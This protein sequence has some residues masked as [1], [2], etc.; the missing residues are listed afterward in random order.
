[1]AIEDVRLLVVRPTDLVLAA[2][3]FVNFGVGSGTLTATSGALVEV[4]LPPQSTGE[5]AWAAGVLSVARVGGP[6][7]LTFSVAAGVV[8]PLTADGVLSALA[9]AV[10]VHGDAPAGA[11]PLSVELPWHIRFAPRPATTGDA[12]LSDVPGTAHAGPTGATGLWH[13]RLEAASGL[14]LVP[15]DTDLDVDVVPP[16]DQGR[17]DIVFGLGSPPG[18][19]PSAPFMD[20]SALGGTM[21]ATGTWQHFSWEHHVVLGRDMAV[22]TESRG[23]LYPFGHRAI[24]VKTSNRRLLPPGSGPADAG[25]LE[26]SWLIVPDPV[27]G[28]SADEAL[29]RVLPFSEVEILE[30]VVALGVPGERTVV[31]RKRFP[32]RLDALREEKAALEQELASAEAS[33][34]PLVE[35]AKQFIIDDGEAAKANLFAQVAPIAAE[36][37]ELEAFKTASDEWDQNHP[38]HFETGQRVVTD[39]VTGE[40]TIEEFSELV[41]GEPNPAPWSQALQNHLEA[42]RADAK[43]F[44]DAVAQ[45]DVNTQNQLAALVNEDAFLAFGGDLGAAMARVKQLRLDIPARAAFIT[46][47]EV[48]AQQDHPV[49]LWPLAPGGTTVQVPIRCDAVRMSMP[50]LFLHDE[51]IGDSEDWP[52]FAP[53][54]EDAARTEIANAWGAEQGRHVP[55]PGIPVDLV[56]APAPAP[57][58]ELPVRRLTFGGAHDGGGFRAILEEAEVVLAAAQELVPGVK[59]AV[60]VTYREAYRLSGEAEHAV[61]ELRDAIPVDFSNV[62]DRAGGLVAPNFAADVISRLHGPVPAGALVGLLPQQPDLATVFGTTKLLGMPLGA[63][64][65]PLTEAVPKPLTIVREPGGGARMSWA[66]LTLKDHGPLRVTKGKTK[67][68]LTVVRSP[69][70]TTTTC[71]LDEFALI[72]PPGP[73]ELV[74]LEFASLRFTQ[75]QG[76]PPDLDVQGLKVKIGGDLGLLEALQDA[77]KLDDVAPRVHTSANGMNVDYTLAV[78]EVTAGMFL[79]QNIAVRAAVDVPF[80]G[81]PIVTLLAFASRDKPF[82]L[83]V[84][85]FGGGGYLIFEIDAG[86]IRTLE[87]SLDFGAAV[88]INIGIAKAE[89]HALGG[90]RFK[91]EGDQVKVSGFLR[92]GGSVDVLGLVSVSVELRVELTYDAP[93]LTGRATA[94]IEIDVTFWSGSIELD[95]GEYTFVGGREPTAIPPS[96]SI[97]VPPPTLPD[98]QK[99]RDAFEHA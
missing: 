93:R 97:S 49:A 91:L 94:V 60:T 13:V 15:I 23:L 36:I 12:L 42:R 79:L 39:P 89:V 37:A 1:M 67:L 25:L 47:I 54:S 72:L 84:S 24:L 4:T 63:L 17:R 50:V 70:T 64:L 29:A 34:G 90:V 11:E 58:D 43:P 45:T 3:R 20:L 88:A 74:R 52:A 8:V 80:D 95:S 10:L 83:G 87:A 61:L 77:V 5:A 78:P 82:H 56:R 31:S 96:S 30:R 7:R 21:S 66:D 68:E 86:G 59:E 32:K 75:E 85:V 69:A 71:H 81:R 19:P 46:D 40:Q 62:A 99:Y 9:S 51:N 55:V 33:I 14:A 16:L 18:L 2:L 76:K 6:S 57:N 35:Q 26:E 53:L 28:R 27:R 92:I 48:E 98:W 38:D 41:P 73:V 65:A 22:R 44:D